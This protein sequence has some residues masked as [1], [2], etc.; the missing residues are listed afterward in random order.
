MGVPIAVICNILRVAITSA[1]YVWDEP[2][3]GQRFMHTFTGM[4]MLVPALLML[5]GLS[6]LL[7]GLFVEVEEDDHDESHADGGSLAPGAKA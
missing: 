4:L 3:L 7:G 5:W 2:E 1:M 6:W